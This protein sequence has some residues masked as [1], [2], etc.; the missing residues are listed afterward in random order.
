MARWW[1]TEMASASQALY[2]DPSMAFDA[3]SLP[4]QA[5]SA[6]VMQYTQAQQD[7]DVQQVQQDRSGFFGTLAGW[8]SD[9]DKLL[10]D[11]PLVGGVWGAAKAVGSAVWYPVDKLATGAHWLYSE[12][13]SQPLSTFFLQSG[14][15]MTGG[16]GEF[17][18][19]EEWAESYGKAE[20]IS[21][22]QAAANVGATVGTQIRETGELSFFQ[23]RDEDSKRATERLLYDSEYWRDKAGWGYTAGTGAADFTMVLGLD[24]TTYILGGAGQ[25][26]KGA[27]SVQLVNK[28][29][30]I[31]RDR[32]AITNTVRNVAGKQPETVSEVTRG[33]KMQEFFDWAASPSTLT[34][35]PRKSAAE[36]EAHPIWG[37]GRRTNPAAAQYSQVLST[38]AREDMELGFRFMAG[39]ISTVAPL[40][41]RGTKTLDDIGRISENRVALDSARLDSELVGYFASLEAR[42]PTIAPETISSARPVEAEA[43]RDIFKTKGISDA[44]AIDKANVDA[45]KEA[46]LGLIDDELTALQ[47]QD[48]NLRKLL[49]ANLGKEVDEFSAIESHGFGG[50]GRAYRAG[51]GSFRSST[52]AA[53]K[54]YANKMKDR[55][56][57]FTTEGYRNGF[58][59]TPTR[60]VQSFDDKVPQGRVNHNEP[61]AGERVFEML[62]EVPGLT[63]AERI[64]LHDSYMT[65][66]DKVTKSQALQAI[67]AQVIQHMATRVNGLDG[68]LARVISGM[69]ETKTQD[70]VKKLLNATGRSYTPSKQSFSGAEGASGR[71][72]DYVE[73]GEAWVLA[74]LAKTQL[75][76]TDSLLP[77]REIERAL[78]R[79]SGAAKRVR[80]NGG[81]AVD[82]AKV[83]ADSFNGVWKAATLLRPAYVPRMVSDEIAASAIKFGFMSR[84][85]I[86]GGVGAKNWTLNRAQ[87]LQAIRGKGSHTP[88]TGGGIEKS[89]V[90]I[91]NPDV[92]RAVNARRNQLQRELARTGDPLKKQTIKGE[93]DS[94]KVE[95]IKVSSALP[96]VTARVKMERE[97]LD[98]LEAE[99]KD[100]QKRHANVSASLAKPPTLGSGPGSSTWTRLGNKLTSLQDKIDDLTMRVDDHK[101]VIDEFQEYY[102]EILRVAV[103]STGRRLG[104]DSFEAFGQRIPQAF[105]GEWANP[106]ARDQISS[107]S[108]MASIFARAEAVDMKRMIQSGSWANIAPDAPNHM[109]A[110]THALN[111]QFGQDDL[112]TKVMED[113]TGAAAKAWL[114][115][116]AGKQHL[117]DLGIRARDPDQLIDDIGTTLDK[118]IPEDTG[119]RE[120]LINGEDITEADLAANIAK[121]D[122]PTVHGEEFL[123]KMAMS[124]KDTAGNIVDKIIEKG[125]K[126]LG[127]I[128]SDVLSRHPT[129]LHFQEGRFK[130]L[131]KTELSYR[132]SVG[133]TEALTPDTLQKILEQS[134]KL[135]RKD[136]SKIVYDPNRTTASEALRFIAPFFSAHA[137][138]LARWGG[139]IAEK[140]RIAGRIAQIYNAPISAG[141]ITDQYGNQVKGDGYADIIDPS[142]IEYD[143]DGAPVPGS[144]KVIGREYVTMEDRVFHFRAPWK[145]KNEGSYPIKISAMNTILPGD[146][147]F[148]PGSGP[149]VQMAGSQIA[150]SSPATGDF[151]Q[152][153]K[154]LPYG[155][156]STW[157][158][159][160]PKYMRAAW[161][162]YKG[163]DPD[164]E[165][166][167]KA[168]LAIWN[169][170]QMEFHQSG[171]AAKFS[172]KDIE[173]EAKQFLF[174]NVLEA[175]GSP[176]QASNTPLTGSPYQFFV[177]QLGQMRKVDPENYRDNFMAKFGTDY[178]GFTASL[179][180][181]LGIA[182]TVS[183]D[184]M[185]DKYA[186]LIAADPD[187]AQF[188]VGNIYNGGPFSS[189]VY[190]KQLDTSYG[191][192]KAREKITAEEAI[193]KS[194]TERGW[195][196]YRQAKSALDAM[197]I[198][199]GFKSY[200]QKGAE[201]YNDA[202][203]Q[204][205]A[206][207]GA[208]YP[209]W[210]NAFMVT[211]KAAV[212]N[213]IHSFE[214][215]VQEERLM[216]DPMRYEMAPLA[217]YLQGRRQFKQMLA[218]RGLSKLSYSIDGKPSGQSADI[219]LAWEQF[220]LGLINSNVAFGD[221]HNR[222]LNNDDLQ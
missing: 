199:N 72:V 140:P 151:L 3:A 51:S 77:V 35:A 108:A 114:K 124:A 88:T 104:E 74:P 211:D 163:S 191:S 120:K 117:A 193:E 55:R 60:I 13:V 63:Q 79:S 123:D 16:A 4:D 38:W 183:A 111:R 172:Q 221:L 21:P 40:M 174:L 203:R 115:T 29:G 196:E 105:S 17:F 71:T 189:S 94:L 100:Y 30:E 136:M 53:E 76:Q 126:R 135:A 205:S 113:S 167:Q 32:G 19:S 48:S 31:V 101:S 93:I 87:R 214:A 96:V 56:G 8:Y 98:N 107:D 202:K 195:Y 2:S 85:M 207:L 127:S 212:P 27:R 164:N 43:G 73:D 156:T 65:A 102:N 9:T 170:K 121:S 149:L 157:D 106:I 152:W 42:R 41:E 18:D 139:L 159:T 165:E 39:D 80:A 109:Q 218:G 52:V 128:P 12:G 190:Q 47:Q 112:F 192:H 119:L 194:Q 133:K 141:L 153:A 37:R 23:D 82:A 181:S 220:K 188:W 142:T 61:D 176:A 180:K 175:W 210:N 178:G 11:T 200:S 67:N 59:G 81:A 206:A 68:E 7:V 145:G 44:S 150:K 116:P 70:T 25:V 179:S 144:G 201:Q 158:A 36:I 103:G 91:E 131:M 62:R 57:R 204:L 217:Q 147:W 129:Y 69:V 169:K 83:V 22:G 1:D 118:Y 33:E 50:L 186:D 66:G 54:K 64:T 173:R 137:D 168:Y 58:Y 171:G 155:P 84:V 15:A 75:S 134:D 130:E 46:K 28:G 209:A 97:A 184:A 146:P 162:A 24:P 99:L 187:M 222:Y 10:S 49:G 92:I 122:F 125:F 78:A 198:R 143:E 197:L 95:K 177:D 89:I 148:N 20:H 160:V 45:W 110:W 6:N 86:D 5:F 166:Y 161:D 138:S 90:K 26:I 185:A 219:G 216:S 215:A 34:G 132:H 14:K 154:I 208:K 182:S 213:R